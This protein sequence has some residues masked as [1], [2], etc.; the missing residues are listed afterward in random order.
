MDLVF[1]IAAISDHVAKFRGDRPR[2]RVDLML[3]KKTAEKHKGR[4]G[5]LQRAALMNNNNSKVQYWS[6]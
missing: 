4:V 2:D 3:K 6:P 5:L 1:K